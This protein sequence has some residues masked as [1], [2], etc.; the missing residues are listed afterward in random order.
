MRNIRVNTLKLRHK[1]YQQKHS[2]S[3]SEIKLNSKRAFEQLIEDSDHYDHYISKSASTQPAS[4]SAWF[5][6]RPTILS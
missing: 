3:I 6:N 5:R 4:T 1:N 2:V